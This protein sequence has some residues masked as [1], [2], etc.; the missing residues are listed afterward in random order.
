MRALVTHSIDS[1]IPKLRTNQRTNEDCLE[2][3]CD[4]A[5]GSNGVDPCPEWTKREII[6]YVQVYLKMA[7][8]CALS[9]TIFLLAGIA[10]A[11]TLLITLQNYRCEYV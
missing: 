1:I 7:G 11:K 8:L 9:S 4:G 3:S 5:S 6:R 10:S 2:N